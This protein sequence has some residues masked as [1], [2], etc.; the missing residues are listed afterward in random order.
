MQSPSYEAGP[1]G[2]SEVCLRSFAQKLR[3]ADS[4]GAAALPA[5][6]RLVA[7]SRRVRLTTS[8][9]G[10]PVATRPSPTVTVPSPAPQKAQS[11]KISPTVAQIAKGAPLWAAG[12]QIQRARRAT[13][14][15]DK[16]RHHRNQRDEGEEAGKRAA[17]IAARPG[18]SRR[19]SPRPALEPA[20]RAGGFP[21]PRGQRRRAR[22]S[23][24]SPRRKG[25]SR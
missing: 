21:E 10:M 5:G 1:L 24:G 6:A 22:A 7:A 9:T 3:A 20:S 11:E 8:H 13:D 17:V 4:R 23:A 16:R 19:R 15:K 18:A 14:V 12:E 25:S 2:T